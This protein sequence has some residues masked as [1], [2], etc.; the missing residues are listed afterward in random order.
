MAEYG[1]TAAGYVPKRADEIKDSINAK[2]KEGWGYDVSMNPQSM[3]QV[4]VTGV[5]DEIAALWEEAQ[6]TYYS[7]YP[8][9]AEGHSLDNVLQFSGLSRRP[10]MIP[11]Q[12]GRMWIRPSM[13]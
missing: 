2:L 7:L 11:G 1:V 13:W 5:S 12:A 4:L 3:I 6:E 9:S 10:R 8:S